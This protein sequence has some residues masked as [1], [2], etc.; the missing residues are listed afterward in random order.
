MRNASRNNNVRYE[1]SYSPF[2]HPTIG[3]SDE[4]TIAGPSFFFVALM[5][6]FVIQMGQIVTEKEFLLRQGMEV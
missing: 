1:P 2:P 4:I 5:F 3:S 6:N